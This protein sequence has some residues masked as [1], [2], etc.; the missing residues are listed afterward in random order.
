M[1]EIGLTK[2]LLQETQAGN[3]ARPTPAAVLHLQHVDLQNIARFG[4]V[5][6]DRSGQ[7]MNPATVDGHKIFHARVRRY[8]AAAC[9]KAAHVHRIS[10]RDREPR[11]K[12]AIPT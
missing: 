2:L 10:R 9:I 7:G 8:L 12:R 6:A 3:H 1:K 5:Y 11:L 4:A